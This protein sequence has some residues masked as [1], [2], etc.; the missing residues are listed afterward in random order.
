MSTP[1]VPIPEFLKTLTALQWE[2]YVIGLL[3]F[4]V[5]MLVANRIG[6][7]V[8]RVISRRSSAQQAMLAGRMVSY[9]LM[10]LVAFEALS[11]AGVDLTVLLGAAGILTVAIGFAAQTSAS[12]LISGLFLMAERPFVI[13]DTIQLGETLGE[14]ASIDL[15]SVKLRTFDNLL[16]RLPNE[17]LLKAQITNLTRYPIRRLDTQMNLPYSEDLARVKKVLDAV[18]EANE[19]CFDE[20]K[21]TL[22]MLAFAESAVSVR[23]SVWTEASRYIEFKN[24]FTMEL[25]AAFD[26]AG[27]RFALPQRALSAASPVSVRLE[28]G[29][30]A[31]EPPDLE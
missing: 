26:A 30:P 1:D 31:Q 16:V 25:K 3:I 10:M 22:F 27:I 13:G 14:V 5:G 2:R 8:R 23:F 19:W 17:T 20:P 4:A 29:N 18:A 21:P 6:H 24:R 7:G 12:N 28:A 11:T 15:L 9:V